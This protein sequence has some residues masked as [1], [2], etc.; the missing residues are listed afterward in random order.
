MVCLLAAATLLLVTPTTHA[1]PEP[2]I[3]ALRVTLR[4]TS[5]W[6]QVELLEA[7]TPLLWEDTPHTTWYNTTATLT[8]G[9]TTLRIDAPPGRG[10]AQA[11]V[12]AAY[13]SPGPLTLRL[14]KGAL[15]S[16]Y[17]KVEALYRGETHT[18]LEVF[19][20]ATPGDQA[21]NRLVLPLAKMVEPYLWRVNL[22]GPSAGREVLA[23]YYPWYGPP[24]ESG[25]ARHWGRVDDSKPQL[26]A[27]TPLLGPYDSLDKGLIETHVGLAHSYGVTCFAVSWWGPGS[28]E[29]RALGLLLNHS[30]PLRVCAY[31]EANRDQPLEARKVAEE[32]EYLADRYGCHPNYLRVGG[33]PVVMVFDAGG[34][35]RDAAFWARVLELGPGCLLVGDTT[36]PELASL[37]PGVHIYNA[38][39]PLNHLAAT[40]WISQQNA[41]LPFASVAELANHTGPTI[42]LTDKIT[43]GTVTPGYDD[44]AVRS[45]AQVVPRM[46]G[47]TYLLYWGRVRRFQVDW[48]LITSWNEWHEGTEVEPSVEHGFTAL[49]T[50]LKQVRL[51]RGAP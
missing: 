22:S 21:L 4:T 13:L 23:L 18:V 7:G 39:D 16:A 11:R 26:S 6:T 47:R 50:T 38:L 14:S 28:Y 36:D 3:L 42:P 37:L 33:R 29:D 30:A 45:P 46:E 44:S 41:V 15:G 10:L 49:K 43:V 24:G 48:V 32:L 27:H 34:G 40:R 25:L 20:R 12:E 51:W 31:Y 9:S 19:H 17:A 8:Q 35:G 5:D 1:A 2:Q